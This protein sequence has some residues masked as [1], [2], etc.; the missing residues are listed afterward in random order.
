MVG[1]GVALKSSSCNHSVN[2]FLRAQVDMKL[3]GAVRKAVK[4]ILLVSLGY[5]FVSVVVAKSVA[6]ISRN[7]FLLLGTFAFQTDL[8]AYDSIPIDSVV[9]FDQVL[10]NI[11]DG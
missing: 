4:A 7:I 6:L 3:T 10:L 9:I 11:G 1:Y 2:V 5:D 8:D